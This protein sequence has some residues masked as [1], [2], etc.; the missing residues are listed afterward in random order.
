MDQTIQ[1]VKT[2]LKGVFGLGLFFGLMLFSANN[3]YAQPANCLP[4]DLLLVIDH[5]GSMTGRTSSGETKWSASSKAFNT[6]LTQYATKLRFGLV[7]FSTTAKLRVNVGPN[8]ANQ[9]LSILKQTNPSGRTA[10]KC[11]M[12]ISYNHFKNTVIPRDSV[13]DR[14]RFV[15]LITD[16]I[17]NECGTNVVPSVARLRSIGVGGANY[18]VKTFVIGFGSG[19]DKTQLRNM[20]VAG[21][22]QK[23][24]QADNFSDLTKALTTIANGASKEIC[25]NKDNDC[26]GVVDNFNEICVATCGAGT[27]TCKNGQFTQCTTNKQPSKEI[28]NKIDDD[29]NG[30]IDDNLTRPCGNNCGTGTETCKLGKWVNCTAPGVGVETCN[31]KDDDCNGRI[32]EGLS[33]EC[34]TKCGKGTQACVQGDWSTCTARQPQPVDACDGIDNDCDGKVDNNATCPGKGK[35]YAGDCLTACTGECKVGEYCAPDG[36]CRPKN[37]TPECPEGQFCRQGA[38]LNADCTTPE[39]KCQAGEI[40]RS[41]RCFRDPCAGVTCAADQFC[42]NGECRHSCAKVQG[43]CKAGEVCK[44]GVCTK[45]DCASKVCADGYSCVNGQCEAQK[46]PNGCPQGQYCEGTVCVDYP[47]KYVQCPSGQTCSNGD[48]YDPNK[49]P[50]NYDPNATNTNGSSA[51]GGTGT[52]STGTTSTGTNSTGTTSTG[53]TSTGST[54]NGSSATGATG[55]ISSANATG[56]NGATAN[57]TNANG[58]NR[59]TNGACVCSSAHL[60]PTFPI[61]FLILFVLMPMMFR[62]RK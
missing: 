45:D 18:D 41:R 30:K 55:S 14:R 42:L 49:L 52:T 26:D 43:T 23:Y 3:A 22:T 5:S 57:G 39:G 50:P 20:A 34:S 46:C 25:D 59:P 54:A 61:S 9:C 24:Y 8:T 27:R 13:K 17:P 62:R 16:G 44:N 33:K 51:T 35:C 29:C 47:C 21:G 28:C 58:G 15:V 48:C 1:N 6:L 2:L 19:V 12:D 11:A 10:M 53:T 60:E 37:C 31:G 40:C 4:S 38:C 7:T 32:D 56:A 36:F